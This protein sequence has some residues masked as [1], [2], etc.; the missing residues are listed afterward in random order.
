M[1]LV[2]NLDKKSKQMFWKEYI[3]IEFC[4]KTS[5]KV[6]TFQKSKNEKKCVKVTKNSEYL[7]CLYFTNI[8]KKRK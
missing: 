5:K 3:K 4:R 2:E 8:N 1:F 6:L 7:K